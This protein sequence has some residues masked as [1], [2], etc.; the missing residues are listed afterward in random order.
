ML[1]IE[2]FTF[3]PFQENTYVIFDETRECVIIDCG[4]YTPG[5]QNELDAYIAKNNL[6]PKYS[7]NTHCHVDHVLGL[8]FLK[9]KYGVESMA[10]REELPMLQ[11]LPQHALMFRLA[12]DNAPEIDTTVDEGDIINFG[13][14]HI[15]VIHTPGHTKGGICL[16]FEEGNFIVSGD[17]LFQGSIG[18]TD[19]PGGNYNTLIDSIKLKLLT[20]DPNT[21]VLPGHGNA[22]TIGK[23]KT[24]NP[25]L[26]EQ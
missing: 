21:N 26:V 14:S 6:V 12:I 1:N 11:M 15:K 17:T 24:S 22:T 4:C 23:E 18:R 9:H 13:T 25:F 8:S 20:L 5:E 19:L 7:I 10:H 2:R 16:H 3:N